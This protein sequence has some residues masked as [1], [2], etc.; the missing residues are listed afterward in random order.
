[1]SQNHPHIFIKHADTVL[2]MRDRNEENRYLSNG[3]KATGS[4]YFFLR[5]SR[6]LKLTA[7]QCIR[8]I[9][10]VENLTLQTVYG[11]S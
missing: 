2:F 4:R 10:T 1:M 5:N 3:E 9:E 8:V 6:M 11:Q 7:P